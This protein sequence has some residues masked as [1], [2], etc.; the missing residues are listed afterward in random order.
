MVKTPFKVEAKYRVAGM[1]LPS[2]K[3]LDKNDIAMAYLK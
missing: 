1:N 2:H 3:V